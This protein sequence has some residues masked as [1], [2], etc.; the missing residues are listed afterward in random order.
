MK[1]IF[2]TLTILMASSN[3]IAKDVEP[4]DLISIR[5]NKKEYHK[6]IQKNELRKAKELLGYIKEDAEELEYDPQ[7]GVTKSWIEEQEEKLDK[8]EA[9]KEK[10]K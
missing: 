7:T 6:A 4:E 1:S 5:V 3:I 8:L 10:K 2:L 9:K